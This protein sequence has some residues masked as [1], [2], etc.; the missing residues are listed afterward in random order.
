VIVNNSRGDLNGQTV[1]SLPNLLGK[2]TVCL[3]VYQE[4]GRLSDL[5]RPPINLE[6]IELVNR[7]KLLERGHQGSRTSTFFQP[8]Y[9][10]VRFNLAY[11]RVGEVQ[12]VSSPTC[13]V[14]I[15][16]GCYF[17]LESFQLCHGC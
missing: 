9:N 12:V 10:D 7:Q 6:P 5:C 3:V 11:L 17:Y 14:N 4:H 15:E 16:V 8:F 2:V 13:G 1:G